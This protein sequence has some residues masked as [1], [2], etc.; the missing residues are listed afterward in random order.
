MYVFFVFQ[1]WHSVSL[2]VV[3]F[4][5]RLVSKMGPAVKF[6]LEVVFIEYANVVGIRRKRLGGNAWQY[7]SVVEQILSMTGV[8]QAPKKKAPLQTMV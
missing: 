5:Y 7:K 3:V 4:R 8:C 6:E 1:L 2:R